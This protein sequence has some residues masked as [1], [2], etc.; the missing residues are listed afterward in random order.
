MAG[1]QTIPVSVEAEKSV[2]SAMLTR[3][4]V[5]GQ[6]VATQLASEHFHTRAMGILFD[7]IVDSFYGDGQIDPLTITEK[8]GPRLTQCL[9]C[10]TDRALAHVRTLAAHQ[11]PHEAVSHAEIIKTAYDRRRLLELAQDVAEQ[12]RVEEIPPGQVAAVLAQRAMEV[13]TS[14]LTTNDILSYGDVGRRFLKRQREMMDARAEGREIG[15]HFGLRF[16][17]DRLHGLQP[18]ELMI[19]AGEPGV[20]KSALAFT[21]A[22]KFAERQLQKSLEDRIGTLVV[23]LEMGEF[24]TAVRLGQA[25]G[26]VDGASLRMGDA[27]EDELGRIAK[28]WAN[29]KDLPLYLNFTGTL[30][31]SQ[32]RALVVES[33]R[34]HKVGLVVVDHMRFLSADTKHDSSADEDE[35]KAKYLKVEIARGLGVGVMLIAHTTKSIEYREDRRPTLSDLRGGGMTAAHADQVTFAYS[36]YMNASEEDVIDGRVTRTEGELIWRKN[37]SGLSESSF[38]FLDP[39]IQLLRDQV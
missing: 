11:N 2:V 4:K 33:V 23:S 6:V 37:R 34:R 15:I 18:G 22:V 39:S 9:G 17:D 13:A 25:E 16:L 32:L 19:L 5:I 21:A 30:K 24:P 12:V 7:Q 36:A 31:A 14:R 1:A 26:C 35:E 8:C 29:H 20:G 27:T 28:A 3:P 10:D 38:Y